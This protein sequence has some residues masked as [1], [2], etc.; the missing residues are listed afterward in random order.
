M[1]NFLNS[2]PPALRSAALG[3]GSVM[4]LL[5]A[6]SLAQVHSIDDL[7][8]VAGSL[9]GAVCQAGS[10]FILDLLTAKPA[11]THAP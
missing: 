10:R 5:L 3:F 6:T 8:I 9:V 7:Q 1:I 4:L 11:E 2:L